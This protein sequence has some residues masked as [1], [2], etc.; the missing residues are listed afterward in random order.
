MNT[1][2]DRLCLHCRRPVLSDQPLW[3]ARSATGLIVGPFHPTCLE[4]YRLKSK[5]RANDATYQQGRLLD[6]DLTTDRG[7]AGE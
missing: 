7:E 2:G 1:H 4:R 3:L 5:A 6:V